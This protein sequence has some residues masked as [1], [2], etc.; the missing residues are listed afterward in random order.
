MHKTAA[1]M[2]TLKT[3]TEEESNTSF[4]IDGSENSSPPKVKISFEFIFPHAFF[5]L[6]LSPRSPF[7]N[8]PSV[9]NIV[10]ESIRRDE[11]TN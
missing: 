11:R 4:K 8:G 7:I 1:P 6:G 5:Y 10:E 9:I 3:A 2:E